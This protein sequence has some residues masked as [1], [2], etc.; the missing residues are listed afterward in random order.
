M[1]PPFSDPDDDP[2]SLSGPPRVLG[3]DEAMRLGYTRNAIQHSVATGHWRRILPRTYLTAD[4]FTWTD[5]VAASLVFAGP[6]SLLS[7]A[8]ALADQGLRCVGRES[9]VLVLVPAQVRMRSVAWVR[10]RATHRMPH[11]ALLPGPRRAPLARAVADLA[12]ERA[13]LDDVRTLVAQA[14]R[15]N[16]CTVDELAAELEEGPRNRSAHLRVAITEVADGAWSAPE[17]RAARALR[18]VHVPPFEQNAR[19]DLPSGGCYHA[20]FLWRDLR[21]VLEIDSVEHHLDPREWRRTMDRHLVLETLGYSVIHRTPSAVRGNPR[22][23]AE[24]VQAWLARR[25]SMINSPGH[26]SEH[27]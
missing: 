21:A 4:T 26:S 14:V 15:R 10:V 12:L 16:L 13:C 1:S 9:T 22:R 8:A 23:F 3:W 20:D 24:D 2:P 25:A 7:G 5:R 6:R 11:A 17:A 19:I 18:A 27:A